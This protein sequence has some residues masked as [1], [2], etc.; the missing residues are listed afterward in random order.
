MAVQS[1]FVVFNKICL[2]NANKAHS[3]SDHYISLFLITTCKFWK[4]LK[5]VKRTYLFLSAAFDEKRKLVVYKIT[6]LVKQ[7]PAEKCEYFLEN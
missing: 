5:N 3:D 6:L 1:N 2:L 7:L 4:A